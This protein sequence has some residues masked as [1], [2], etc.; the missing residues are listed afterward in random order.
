[1]QHFAGQPVAIAQLGLA[2]AGP[3]TVTDPG[4][5]K[6]TLPPESASFLGANQ[7][8]IYT[9]TVGNVSRSFAVNPDPAES[10]TTPLAPDELERF[11]LPLARPDAAPDPAPAATELATAAE[12]EGRQKFWRWL[13]AGALL[14][15]LLET[16]IAGLTARR[17]QAAANPTP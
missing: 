16:L 15:L 2:A 6:S 5:N 9:A 10:R 11:G 4:G 8:G 17:V 13:L 7:P 14:I 1:M 12:T 3:V